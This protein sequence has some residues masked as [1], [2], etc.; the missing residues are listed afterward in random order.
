MAVDGEVLPATADV[1][2]G[3]AGRRA[4]E[5][6]ETTSL[7]PVVTRLN[8]ETRLGRGGGT[9]VTPGSLGVLSPCAGLSGP[10]FVSPRAGRLTAGPPAT[11]R[12]APS[13]TW[14]CEAVSPTENA[15]PNTKPSRQLFLMNVIPPLATLLPKAVL[16][17]DRA[18]SYVP[19]ALIIASIVPN[20]R[21]KLNGTG[22]SQRDFPKVGPL[23]ADRA[24][25]KV[26]SGERRHPKP[27]TGGALSW[28]RT[29][30]RE[31]S[32]CT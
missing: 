29:C 19:H 1:A 18:A 9:G 4:C 32:S 8:D 25:I 27:E 13:T 20:S 28:S 15:S 5:G 12:A 10:L 24:S 17:Q 6:A 7:R 2:P 21:K 23:A 3:P 16:L 11:S 14:A 30:R 26:G 31:K 22:F